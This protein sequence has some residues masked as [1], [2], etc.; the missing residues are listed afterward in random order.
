[1]TPTSALTG[2][3]TPAAGA[4]ERRPPP[5]IAAPPEALTTRDNNG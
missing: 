5:G 4:R 1:M 2:G 3:R